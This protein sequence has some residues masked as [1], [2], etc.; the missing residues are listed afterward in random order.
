MLAFRADG[1][2]SSASSSH[3]RQTHSP[4][5]SSLALRA[6]GTIVT[7][8]AAQIGGRSSASTKR[9]FLSL[10]VERPH[11]FENAAEA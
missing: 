8:Q 4:S 3:S 2:L 10:Q 9:V 5:W 6:A 7:P 1:Y 11:T